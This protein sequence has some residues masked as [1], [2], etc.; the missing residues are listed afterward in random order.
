[1]ALHNFI[2]D[3]HREDHDFVQWQSDD[4]GE[5]E[6]EAE[7]DDDDDDGGGGGGGGGG[8]IVYEPTGDR[9]M[10][11]LRKSITDEYGRGRLPY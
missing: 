2:R 10:E 3:S 11:A 5:R 8:H 1:M 4:D 6:G 9:T 7:G